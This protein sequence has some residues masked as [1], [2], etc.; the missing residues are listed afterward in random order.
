MLKRL[1]DLVIV[2][3]ANGEIYSSKLSNLEGIKRLR[4][5]PDRILFCGNE[6]HPPHTRVSNNPVCSAYMKRSNADIQE[7]FD[8]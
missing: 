3:Q 4:Y 8:N 7:Q 1:G 6:V 2:I 5:F